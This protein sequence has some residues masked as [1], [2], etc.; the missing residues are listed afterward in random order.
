[1]R[2]VAIA[3]VV[4]LVACGGGGSG[5]AGGTFKGSIGGQTFDVKDAMSAVVQGT[6]TTSQTFRYGVVVLSRAPSICSEFTA[7]KEPQANQYLLLEVADL[8]SSVA[9]VPKGPGTYPIV[10]APGQPTAAIAVY[11]ATDA[12]CTPIANTSSS[13]TSGSV[14]LTN[15][16]STYSGSFDLTF[17][18]GDSVTGTFTAPGCAGLESLIES[19]APTAC[20]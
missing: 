19:G 11:F 13:A 8:S 3:G 5:P 15:V 14:T 10:V 1:M 12:T 16:G 6:T 2:I 9:D 20:H 4:A 7:R 17:A 18:T